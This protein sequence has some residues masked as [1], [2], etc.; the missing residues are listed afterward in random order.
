MLLTLRINCRSSCVSFPLYRF[1]GSALSTELVY[2]TTPSTFCQHYF[3]LFWEFFSFFCAVRIYR[4]IYLLS[5][6]C[7][8]IYWVLFHAMPPFVFVFCWA[9]G[10]DRSYIWGVPGFIGDGFLTNEW[11]CG[12]WAYPLSAFGC[13]LP[14][15]REP[16][17]RRFP[18]S[19]P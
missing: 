3:S 8:S 7:F 2:N 1:Q 9:C 19:R 18:Q 6:V 4:V 14:L 10:L 13:L 15:R 16:L 12:G 17:G 11:F 5:F